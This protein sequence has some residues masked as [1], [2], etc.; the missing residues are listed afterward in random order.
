MEKKKRGRPKKPKPSEVQQIVRK[1]KFKFSDIELNLEKIGKSLGKFIMHLIRGAEGLNPEEESAT[2]MYNAHD[3]LQNS[4]FTPNQ[5]KFQTYANLVSDT[6]PK[7][8]KIF[9]TW[10][11]LGS[12]TLIA[13][14][15]EQRK[16]QILIEKAK[17]IVSPQQQL[18]LT[19]PMTPDTKQ[20]IQT[21]A[22]MTTPTQKETKKGILR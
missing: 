19:L 15:G 17:G 20:P 7:L 16:E 3:P 8:F 12:R 4:R 22:P 11:E 1:E 13:L 18:S 6:Y 9:K 2:K 10:S 14:N 21:E 5:Q